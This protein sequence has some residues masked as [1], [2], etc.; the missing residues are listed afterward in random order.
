MR[1]TVTDSAKNGI[2]KS[3][4]DICAK[5][6]KG[7]AYRCTA[8]SFQMHPC[9]ALLSPELEVATHPHPLGL[10]AAFNPATDHEY[11]CGECKRKR[12][13]R[14]YHCSICDYHL[15]AVCAKNFING[16]QDNGLKGI[17]KPSMLGTA[18]RVASQVVAEFI[19]GLIEG[20]GEGVGQALLQTMARS[21]RCLSFSRSH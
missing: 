11:F 21:G 10:L 12:S 2:L 16:L 6:S 19:G 15:H 1:T 9:C 18:A 5:P 13:G 3:R 4:C 8:C 17:D 20:L 7:C 14:A